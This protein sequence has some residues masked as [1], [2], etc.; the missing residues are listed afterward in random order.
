MIDRDPQ[1]QDCKLLTTNRKYTHV[2]VSDRA[3]PLSFYFQKNAGRGRAWGRGYHKQP[4]QHQMNT[5]PTQWH[6]PLP[7]WDYTQSLTSAGHCPQS[8]MAR[9]MVGG[10]LKVIRAHSHY[11]RKPRPNRGQHA[12]SQLGTSPTVGRGCTNGH[13]KAMS[14]TGV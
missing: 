4:R 7:G 5:P 8:H 3:L 1:L 6:D 2:T 13:I 14:A 9:V 12:H 11:F 10:E